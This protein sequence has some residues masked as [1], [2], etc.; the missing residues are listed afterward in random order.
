MTYLET[1]IVTVDGFDPIEYQATSR[2]KARYLCF[3]QYV[4][5]W[6]RVSFGNFLR[7]STVRRKVRPA[8]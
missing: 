5:G 4:D 7:I 6:T 8:N 3:R 2:S 1:Y